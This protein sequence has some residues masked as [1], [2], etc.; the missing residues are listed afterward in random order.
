MQKCLSNLI[1]VAAVM[2]A[3]LPASSPAQSLATITVEAGNVQRTDVPL[4]A[5][6]AGWMP[7]W[8]P[9]SLRLEEV[10]GSQRVGVPGQIT[11]GDVPR[12]G[13]ILSGQTPAG[14]T[15]TFELVKGSP[16]PS[17]D[18]KAVKDANAPVVRVEF[19]RPAEALV[20]FDGKDF[21][22]WQGENGGDIRWTLADGVMTVAPRSGGIMTRQP[23]RDFVMHVEFKEPNMPEARGQAKGNSGVYIQRRYELQILDSY[24][25]QSK[26]NDCGAIYTFKAPDL[27][28]CKKPLEWQTYDI[29]F[30]AAR[31]EGSNKVENARLTVLQNGLLIQDNVSVSNKTGAGRPEGP[32]PAPILLQEHGNEVSF[33]NIWIRAIDN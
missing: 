18:V 27:N 10:K 23:Y 17:P 1:I 8:K 19:P 12:I 2:V 30:R 25:L 16:M 24:G 15:R 20:L 11:M 21:S 31:Y 26:N 22:Q 7:E 6:L 28:A 3:F 14:Q 4:S 13:W 9:E 5:T 32:D 33:R 29:R